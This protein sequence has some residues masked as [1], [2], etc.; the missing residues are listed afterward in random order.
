V[1]RVELLLRIQEDWSSCLE[2]EI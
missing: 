2:V 1:D